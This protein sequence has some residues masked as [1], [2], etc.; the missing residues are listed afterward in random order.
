MKI[1]PPRKEIIK[2]SIKSLLTITP[3]ISNA[4]I[5]QS[6]G[7]HRNTIAKYLCEIYSEEEKRSKELWI[8]LL[9]ELLQGSRDRKMQLEEIWR[10]SYSS[11]IYK[12][13]HLVSIVEQ[14]WKIQ[15][16]MYK[17][18]LEFLGKRD[19]PRTLVQVNVSK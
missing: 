6:V 9:K 15:K 7:L 18:Q 16:D 12:P 4:E 14:Y 8:S 13:Q 5:G 19:D 3:R 2:R 10:D 17:I 1:S 11:C